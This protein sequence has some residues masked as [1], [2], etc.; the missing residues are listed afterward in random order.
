MPRN[1]KRKLSLRA[2]DAL[3]RYRNKL[4]ENLRIIRRHN[5][6]PDET[7]QEIIDQMMI[8][9]TRGYY[10]DKQEENINNPHYEYICRC[11][12]KHR[13]YMDGGVSCGDSWVAVLSPDHKEVVF[14]ESSENGQDL[15]R[16]A[17]EAV[18]KY[19]HEHNLEKVI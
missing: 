19:I 13:F 3:M 1:G 10:F 18:G 7:Y 17:A 6:M 2:K 12:R 5:N 4:F 11:M 9:W 15:W 14:N 8:A 16:R